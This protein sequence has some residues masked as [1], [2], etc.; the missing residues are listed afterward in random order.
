[1]PWSR[2]LVDLTWS[3]NYSRPFKLTRG[4][5]GQ[6]SREVHLG[7][8]SVGVYYVLLGVSACVCACHGSDALAMPA[9]DSSCPLSPSFDSDLAVLWTGIHTK[10]TE[11]SLHQLS[12]TSAWA[13][14][15]HQNT[16]PPSASV[17]FARGLLGELPACVCVCVPAAAV[18]QCAATKKDE[19]KRQRDSCVRGG[20]LCYRVCS[21]NGN[22]LAFSTW[23]LSPG[24]IL[25]N[26]RATA[27]HLHPDATASSFCKR[28]D[29]PSRRASEEPS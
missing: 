10:K 5:G 4:K 12:K 3:N 20:P 6:V 11:E 23:P 13:D 1:M 19:C 26:G 18:I 27:H 25:N 8:S 17:E 22:K 21:T 15:Y 7:Y 28:P 14:R 9:V 2:T 24:S 29:A 16:A